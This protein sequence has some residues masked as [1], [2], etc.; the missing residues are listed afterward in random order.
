MVHSLG[1]PGGRGSVSSR[2]ALGRVMR[3]MSGFWP[4]EQG[5]V[6]VRNCRQT[7]KTG[8]DGGS[9][10]FSGVQERVNPICYFSA[11]PVVSKCETVDKLAKRAT[12]VQHGFP[13]VQHGLRWF[14][15][16]CRWFSTVC[17]WFSTVCRW[18]STVC[19]GSARFSGGSARFAVVQH[20][21]GGGVSVLSPQIEISADEYSIHQATA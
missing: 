2:P 16:V 14:S 13:V 7:G 9:A 6:K 1:P 15:T 5:G 8:H 11:F 19:G 18:F 21:S 20:G 17:R 10:R 3:I 12:M 4:G